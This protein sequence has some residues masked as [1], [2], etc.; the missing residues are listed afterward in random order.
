MKLSDSDMPPSASFLAAR[1]IP[2]RHYS[3]PFFFLSVM[4]IFT[5]VGNILRVL[6]TVCVNYPEYAA[7]STWCWFLHSIE[8]YF[9]DFTVHLV[10]PLNDERK[11]DFPL[12]L[13][14]S[15]ILGFFL[16]RRQKWKT[17][18]PVLE[19]HEKGVVCWLLFA[20]KKFVIFQC[21]FII[22][23]DY[24][25]RTLISTISCRIFLGDSQ[26]LTQFLS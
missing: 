17:R 8:V 14:V 25:T 18:F 19:E 6:R 21:T 4:F 23:L 3:L 24:C 2:L 10:S 26:I 12:L 5:I 15:S 20:L 9:T 7:E 1:P 22:N 11:R 13:V 16:V